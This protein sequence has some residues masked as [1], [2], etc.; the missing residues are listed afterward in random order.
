MNMSTKDYVLNKL[1]SANGQAISGQ[2]IADELEVSRTAIWKCVKELEEEGYS[3]ESIRKKG[4][5]LHD[6]PDVLH[7]AH[8][9]PYLKTEQY[10]RN[11]II[12]DEVESTQKIAHDE[13]QQEVPNGTL[14]IADSQT[15]GRGRLARTWYSARGKGIWMSLIA[16]PHLSIEQA[17]QLTLVTAVA[18]IHTLKEVTGLEAQIKWPNDILLNG[19]KITGILTEL[20]ADPDRIQAVI[21]GIGMNVNQQETD[22]E[23]EITSIATSLRI[24]SGKK[25]E[26][27]EII[28]ELMN[29]L[30][31]YVHM[32]ET[33]GFSPIKMLW[34]SYSVTIGKKLTARMVNETL[35][36]EAIGISEN[37]LLQLKL[38]DGSIRSIYSA[39]IEFD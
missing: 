24:E 39:D 2:D 18:I 11:L 26:R 28:G 37:G 13:A 9:T 34:E 36:G 16:R 33:H 27:A 1:L 19:K 17:P 25:W 10:G 38:R 22:F 23:D 15:G 35:R 21:I 29:Q 30:E 8:I 32:Y 20:Q 7:E 14:V 6:S 3:I 5:V 12:F 31:K 4:Y